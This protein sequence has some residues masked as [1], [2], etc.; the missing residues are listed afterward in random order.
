MLGRLLLLFTV[1]PLVELVLL[2]NIAGKTSPQ[3]TLGLVLA[4]GV[5]GAALARHEGLRCWRR[6]H[7]KMAAGEFPGDPLLD[8]LM[9][10]VAGALLVT[11]GVLTD[12][13]GF[14]LL[15]P[16]F[17][18]IVKRRLKDRFRVRMGISS[19]TDRPI[20]REEIIDVRVVDAPAQPPADEP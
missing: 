8:A 4:T 19:A 12:L 17:R 13:V 20:T 18:R 7:E 14:A 11:P 15:L 10:L 2:L 6:V 3:F 9:I 16:M 5:A 1:V